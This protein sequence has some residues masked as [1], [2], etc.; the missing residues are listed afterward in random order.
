[1]E[2]DPRCLHGLFAFSGGSDDHQ[3][4]E[5]REAERT[6]HV[7]LYYCAEATRAEHATLELFG[8]D[9]EVPLAVATPVDTPGPDAACLGLEVGLAEP[10][11]AELVLTTSADFLPVGDVFFRFY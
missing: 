3:Y 5:L 7:E 2:A 4:V 9:S 11:T 1:L 6:Y 10:V 8:S